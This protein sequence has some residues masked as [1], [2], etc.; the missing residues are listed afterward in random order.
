[1]HLTPL[2]NLPVESRGQIYKQ[3]VCIKRTCTHNKQMCGESGHTSH[4]V[5]IIR[6]YSALI[7]A[8]PSE[9]ENI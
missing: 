4:T 8:G 1:M 5:Q 3:C 7:R 2:D 9:N 6:P